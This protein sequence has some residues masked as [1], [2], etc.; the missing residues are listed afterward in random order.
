MTTH[1]DT[2]TSPDGTRLAFERSGSG[3][4]I[5]LVAPALADRKDHR[6][7]AVLLSESHT[8]VN[9]DRRGRGA[10]T[11][12]GEWEIARE[13]DDIE[14]LIDAHGG[15]AA[16]FG[17]SSG[18]VLALDAAAALPAKVSRVIA[19]EPPVIVDG[20]R[21][22]VPHDLAAR[23]T[24]LIEQGHPSRAV[25]EFNRT[26]LGASAFM[27]AAM[28][29]MVPVWRSMVDM[30]PRTVYDVRLCEG[31]QD[32]G[33]LPA[34][35]WDGLTAPTLLLVGGK[36]EPFMKT[37]SAALA[38]AVGAHRE[39]IPGAHH[40]TPVMKPRLLQPALARFLS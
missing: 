30:A 25:T 29:L 16:L 36:A 17:A 33:P 19:Y 5:V 38:E 6:K 40:G 18:A 26:A 34:G 7:L 28:R 3:P 35:R 37:G 21:S 22:P 14:A 13:I 12:A 31:L 39:E 23:L 11:D 27:V 8:V 20:S 24:E 1:D 15:T 4:V 10:S 2:V 9:Y 32:G